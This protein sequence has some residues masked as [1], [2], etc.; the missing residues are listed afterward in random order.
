[1][2]ENSNPL[3]A[4]SDLPFGLPDYDAILPEHYLPAFRAAF[5]LSLIHI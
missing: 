4:G 2:A 5:A 1:M 3:L